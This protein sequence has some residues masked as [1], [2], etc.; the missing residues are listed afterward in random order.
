MKIDHFALLKSISREK[1][2]K[3]IQL[4]HIH[5]PFIGEDIWTLYELSWLNKNGLP[6]IAIAKIKINI[7][8]KNIIESKSLKIYINSFNQKKFNSYID[9]LNILEFDLSKCACGKVS[10]HFFNLT[11][12]KN[13]KISNFYGTCIDNKN[14]KIVSYKYNPSFLV[15][16]DK[17]EIIKESLYSHLLK[18]NCPIT[19]Q[20]D[21]ASIQIIYTG[22][23]IDHIGLL[24]YLVSFRSCNEF[25][26]EC[27]ERIFNDIEK[28][29]KP[30][31]LT[32]YAKYTRRGG[33]DINPWRSNSSF[34]PCLIRMARQ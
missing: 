10:V 14:I 18:S 1:H 8:S 13:Q 5:L 11:E 12:I 25:H 20:P 7:T 4:N 22:R 24:F 21:W 26:E 9:F 2:R 30:E 23:A 34:L 19:K 33:I 17:K 27:I 32:V 3:F 31:K 15:C 28:I 6:L 16:S 29:C